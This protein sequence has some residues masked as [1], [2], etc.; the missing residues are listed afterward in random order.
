MPEGKNIEGIGAILEAI[1]VI[2]KNYFIKAIEGF[3]LPNYLAKS[4]KVRYNLEGY[5]YPDTYNLKKN[6]DAHVIIE[7]MISNFERVMKETLEGE[8]LPTK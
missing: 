7:K 8:N 3:E 2:T 6:M 4:N 5:L 1:E